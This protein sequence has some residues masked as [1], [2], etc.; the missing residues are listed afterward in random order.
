[1]R[2][3]RRYIANDGTEFKSEIDCRAYEA[4]VGFE[5][6]ANYIQLFD[7]LGNPMKQ[8]T[9]WW[10]V[11]YVKVNPSFAR[12]PEDVVEIWEEM[13]DSELDEL[14]CDCGEGWYFQD[15][16]DVWHYWPNFVKE[17]EDRNESMDKMVTAYGD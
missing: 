3:E 5:R 2:M 12:A 9:E 13:M 11:G 10:R 16:N 1:M 17:Y 4:R 7:T 15:D 6:L 8:F 14:I